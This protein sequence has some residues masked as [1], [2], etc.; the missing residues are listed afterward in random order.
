MAKCVAHGHESVGRAKSLSSV[1]RRF[2]P[3][4]T[5]TRQHALR[6]LEVGASSRP[7]ALVDAFVRLIGVFEQPQIGFETK[8]AIAGVSGGFA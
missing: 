6:H 2:H 8:T 4:F 7:F 5:L 1:A 3:L